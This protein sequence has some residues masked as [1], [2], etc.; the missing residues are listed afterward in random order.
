MNIINILQNR[1]LALLV[2][3]PVTQFAQPVG[4]CAQQSQKYADEF[5]AAMLSANE[6]RVSRLLSEWEA[7]CG[8][9]EPVFRAK[10][11][12]EFS[13]DNTL[14]MADKEGLLEM[15]VAFEVRQSLIDQMDVKAIDEHYGLYPQYFGFIPING[16]FDK[17]T[18]LMARALHNHAMAQT[19]AA[20]LI[21][22]Y[23]GET[24]PFFQ[25]LK[26]GELAE[27]TLSQEYN[28]RVK[29]LKR[30]PEYNFG[31]QAGAWIPNGD[32]AIIGIRPIVCFYAGV[33]FNTTTLNA[34]L[35]IRAGK[36]RQPF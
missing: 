34:V 3:I 36:S 18:R 35:G 5:I 20:S 4:D 14:T 16:N 24:S 7:L 9:T 17:Q 2:L 29:L 6:E 25:S 1:L 10:L 22:M 11:L 30:M 26:S 8:T 13:L 28:A 33:S 27:S 23:G 12:F 31:I 32:L 21:R 19:P 15:A